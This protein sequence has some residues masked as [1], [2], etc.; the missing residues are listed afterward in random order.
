M[1]IETFWP[2]IDNGYLDPEGWIDLDVYDAARSLWERIARSVAVKTLSDETTGYR[3]MCKAAAI[4]TRVRAERQNIRHLKA[5]MLV[6]FKRLVCD[7]AVRQKKALEPDSESWQTVVWLATHHSA[8]H[9]LERKILIGEIVKRMDDQTH[10]VF[11]LLVLGH[12]FEEIAQHT[13]RECGYVRSRFH[14][15]LK[16]IARDIHVLTRPLKP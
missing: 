14:K 12:S 11:Q 15:R 9:D 10:M 2:T 16:R 1:A 4:V 13:G 6:T 5:Y 3:L 7:E 8:A